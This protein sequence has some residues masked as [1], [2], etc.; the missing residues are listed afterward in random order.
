MSILLLLVIY[1]IFISLGLPDSLIGSSWPAIYQ[2][3]NVSSSLQG[4]LTLIISLCT[5]ISSFASSKLVSTFKQ[6][7]VVIISICLTV[8]GLICISYSS[9]FVYLC[10][11]AIPLGFGAG[12]IDSTLNNYVA[13][14]YKA[15]HLNFLH[16][17]WGIGAGISPFIV[18]IFLTNLNGWRN[19]AL[20]LAIIQSFILLIS[21]CSIK[22]WDKA[23]IIFSKREKDE[24]EEINA[25]NFGFIKTFRIK[26]VIFALIAFFC[27]MAVEQT[28]AMWF[29]TMLVNNFEVS[30]KI[31]N[32]WNGLFYLGILSGRIISGF[33]SLKVDDKNMIRLGES[34]LLIGIILM[35]L[36]FNLYI[37]PASLFIIGFGCGPIYPSIIHSTPTRFTKTYSQSVMSIQVSCAYIAN[38][39]ISPLFGVI[40]KYTTYLLLPYLLLLFFIIMSACNEVVNI[41]VKDKTKLVN[42]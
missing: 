35:T 42:N 29:S 23:E 3:L 31:A 39:T 28:A 40:G 13:I 27:Y 6:K 24:D 30:V 9:K 12:A 25:V 41:K 32:N 38:I 20:C 5:I 21:I 22:L 4:F 2:S 8:I 18:G 19:G 15:I 1:L 34:I 14:N 7:G 26:G 17:F 36:R 37:M 11:S 10:L 33:I 16:A